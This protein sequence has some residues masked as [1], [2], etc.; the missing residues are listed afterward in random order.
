[1]TLTESAFGTTLR[2]LVLHSTKEYRDGHIASGMESGMQVTFDRLEDLLPQIVLDEATA[3]R[4]RRVAAR[5]TQ[6][7]REVPADAWDRPAPPEGWVARDVVRHMVEWM[8]SMLSAAGIELAPGPSVDE[9]PVGAWTSLADSLQSLLDDP[10]IAPQEFEMG[11]MGTQTV[12]H[13]IS[14]AMLGDI[15]IHTWDLARATGLDESLDPRIVTEMLIGM[16]PMDEVLRTSG[17][18]G[19]RVLVPDDSDDQTKLIAFTGRTP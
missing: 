11:P 13:A 9:D 3:E 5:F 19:P 4:F 12:E 16:E 14:M 2:T 1:M 15:V 8:P 6:R 17:H 7:V 18:Y 10:E